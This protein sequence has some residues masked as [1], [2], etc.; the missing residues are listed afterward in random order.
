MEPQPPRG[1][2]QRDPV[3]VRHPGLAP[4][5]P[6]LLVVR[7]A[8]GQVPVHL[9]RPHLQLQRQLPAHARQRVPQAPHR[10]DQATEWSC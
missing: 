9:V 10:H 1:Q 8:G 3:Q 7:D 5:A 4:R 2:H 6:R